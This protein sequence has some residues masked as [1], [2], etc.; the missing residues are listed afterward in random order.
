MI[1]LPT[2]RYFL[3]YGQDLYDNLEAAEAGNLPTPP[4]FVTEQ[5]ALFASIVVTPASAS[6]QSIIDERPRLGFASPSRTG[7]VT[8]HGNLLGLLSDDHP[9]Y[10]LV[11]GTRAMSG[12]LSMNGNDINGAGTV[13]ATAV[14]ASL[15][16]T[17]SWAINSLTSSYATNFTVAGTITAQTLIVQTVTSSVLYTSGSNIFGDSVVDTHDFTG[18]VRI[19]GSFRLP[20]AASNPTGTAAGQL[21]YNTAD[22]NIYRYNGS[23]WVAAAGSSGTSGTSGSSGSSG[24]TGTSGSSG[25]GGSSGSSGSTGTS[26][27]SGSTGTSGSSGSTGTSGSSGS[28]GSSGSS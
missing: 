14:S 16:G 2:T 25:S 8:L 26:G 22:N 6:I 20:T 5:F 17:S 18:S 4:S 21:Y 7:I 23:T 19:T 11:D 9:Q 13:N 12:D 1:G 3:V 27:S 28:T 24:S 10:L 15:H